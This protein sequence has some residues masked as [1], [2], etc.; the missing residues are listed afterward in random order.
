MAM[1]E[2]LPLPLEMVAGAIGGVP[3]I[4]GALEPAAERGLE[5]LLAERRRN[6]SRLLEMA[7]QR[8]RMSRED[9]TDLIL[10]SPETLGL[11]TRILYTAGMNGHDEVIQILAGFLGDA[12]AD[13]AKTDDVQAFVGA[14]TQI[15][16]RHI[17][18]LE[19]I[20]AGPPPLANLNRW[21]SG[22]LE[23][24]LPYRH[25]VT[26]VAVKGLVAAGFVSEGGFDGG[27][28]D[29]ETEPGGTVY[30]ISDVG[31]AVLDVLHTMR[32]GDQ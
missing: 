20:A 21:T 18:V 16:G 22:L 26:Q 31:L 2:R 8:A 13:P 3:I 25:E 6:S 11:T 10:E 15:S 17:Q 32:A 12:L 1:S 14:M 4:G 30:L 27:G 24:A 29:Q 9:L 7:C 28:A 23:I 5:Q 19:R